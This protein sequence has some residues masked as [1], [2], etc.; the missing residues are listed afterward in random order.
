VPSDLAVY[1]R[2][3]WVAYDEHSQTLTFDVVAPEAEVCRL[4][5]DLQDMIARGVPELKRVERP[6]NDPVP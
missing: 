4:F 6:A 3:L 1:D 5:D 2:Q